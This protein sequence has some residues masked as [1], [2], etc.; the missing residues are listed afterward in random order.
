MSVNAINAAEPQKKSNPMGMAIGTG[1]VTGA[2]GAGAG[3]MW[4]GKTPSLEEVFAQD[5][6]AFT[7]TK[8]AIKGK[9]AADVKKVDDAHAD[10]QTK[11]KKERDALEKAQ[12]EVKRLTN[13]IKDYADKD[14][15]DNKV[16]EAKK[17]LN[18]KKVTA[19]IDEKEVENYTYEQAKQAKEDKQNAFNAI[20]EEGEKKTGAQKALN[21]AEE[22]LKLFEAEENAF[23]D[24]EK[25][26]NDAK[27]AR[28][29]E[30]V[31]AAKDDKDPYKAAKNTLTEAEGK[32]KTATDTAIG[33]LADDVKAAFNKVKGALTEGKGKAAMWWGLGAAAVGLIL[34]YIFGGKKEA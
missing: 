27:A 10:I 22:N 32:L 14:N 3:Y 19:K 24:A 31:N 25:A 11:V 23:K 21:E 4:G 28:F 34:G 26:V 20:T 16:N 33:N 9:D 1:V 29:E 2:A 30:L 6:D 7:S 12:D 15:L 17:A 8:E 18:E 13:E 5:H